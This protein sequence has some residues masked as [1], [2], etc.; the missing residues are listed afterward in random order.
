[1]VRNVGPFGKK[2]SHW[3][4]EPLILTEPLFPWLFGPAKNSDRSEQAD[5]AL[6]CKPVTKATG[7]QQTAH[8]Y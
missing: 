2:Q 6:L 4:F 8:F 3:L 1:M 7:R 5:S